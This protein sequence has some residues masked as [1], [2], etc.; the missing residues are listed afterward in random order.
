MRRSVSLINISFRQPR[1]YEWIAE[2]SG[3]RVPAGQMRALARIADH[4]DLRVTDLAE[5]L[6][7][8]VATTSRFV[9]GLETRG[10]VGR[11]PVPGDGRAS[12]FRLTS[13]GSAALDRLLDAW[14]EVIKEVVEDW[15]PDDVEV[16][17]LL[18]RRFGVGLERFRNTHLSPRS[19]LSEARRTRPDTVRRRRA[20]GE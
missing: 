3:V 13:A 19:S 7:L 17:S 4:P 5:I 12:T 14:H 15:D 9:Q 8:D 2:R 16:F 18:F 10:L 1:F 11:R 20:G 6:A